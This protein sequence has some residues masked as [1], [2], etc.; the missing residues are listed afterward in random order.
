MFGELVL[1][2]VTTLY[3]DVFARQGGKCAVTFDLLQLQ[4]NTVNCV[5]TIETKNNEDYTD[6][7]W[8]PAAS[9]LAAGNATVTI[10]QGTSLGPFTLV[11]K[12]LMELVRIS[13]VMSPNN[14]QNNSADALLR[15]YW[16]RNS[17]S[18]F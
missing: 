15:L 6:A 7:A 3:T 14:P 16:Y 8:T 2:N 12:E 11:A 9:A 1:K 10:T 4:G 17:W 5:I 18:P 13:F